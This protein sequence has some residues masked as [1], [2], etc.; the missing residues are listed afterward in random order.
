MVLIKLPA[1][2]IEWEPLSREIKIDFPD[3]TIRAKALLRSDQVKI[4]NYYMY[5]WFQKD[6]LN[7]N[8]GGYSGEL[9]QGQY[10]VFDNQNRLIT[11]GQFDSGLK[12]GTWKYWYSNGNLRMIQN[13]KNSSLDGEVMHFDRAGEITAY[14]EYKNGK[15]VKN[16]SLTDKF[17]NSSRSSDQD[18]SKVDS[19]NIKDH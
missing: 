2:Q 17:F 8:A 19:L 6:Q 9:L 14:Y 5:Y 1:Q 12:T 7:R 18:S 11:L 4:N 13:W 3:S 16:K 15:C 10:M